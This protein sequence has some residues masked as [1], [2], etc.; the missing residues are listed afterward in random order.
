MDKDVG[1]RV[2]MEEKQSVLHPFRTARILEM[3]VSK[4]FN[5]NAKP[6]L[7][8]VLCNVNGVSLPK[9]MP[10]VWPL[11]LPLTPRLGREGGLNLPSEDFPN[12][13]LRTHGSR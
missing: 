7:L 11:G 5:S 2:V 12:A 8:S 4:V 9:L 13:S 10:M 3:T 6:L 1:H